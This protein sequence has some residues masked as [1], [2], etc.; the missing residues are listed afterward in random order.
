MMFAKSF[1]RPVGFRKDCALSDTPSA[2][3]TIALAARLS[4]LFWLLATDYWL[5]LRGHRFLNGRN[6]GRGP[7]L[8]HLLAVFNRLRDRI[9]RDAVDHEL[10]GLLP[11]LHANAV[12]RHR[13]DD[14]GDVVIVVIPLELFVDPELF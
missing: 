1:T 10:A 4:L 3:R 5:L 6:G 12:R 7:E 2:H 8:H 14:R 13:R 9:E 11:L